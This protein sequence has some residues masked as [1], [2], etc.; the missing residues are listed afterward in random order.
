M[1]GGSLGRE[2]WPGVWTAL[3]HFAPIGPLP[4][5][6]FDSALLVI[7]V[8]VLAFV[9]LVRSGAVILSLKV[10]GFVASRVSRVLLRAWSRTKKPCQKRLLPPRTRAGSGRNPRL[11]PALMRKSTMS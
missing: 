5:T 1:Q 7:F 9:V 8:F 2:L 3:F 11:V 6:P 4:A 10:P